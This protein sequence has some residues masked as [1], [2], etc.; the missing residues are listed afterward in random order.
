MAVI[1]SASVHFVFV[2]KSETCSFI[3][4]FLEGGRDVDDVSLKMH[5]SKKK[6]GRRCNWSSNSVI[7]LTF[8]SKE[9]Q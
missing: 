4:F 7:C 6:V 1:L 9:K 5:L 2:E 3:L 8:L